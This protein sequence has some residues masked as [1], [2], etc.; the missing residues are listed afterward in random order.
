MRY[1]YIVNGNT[2]PG[3]LETTRWAHSQ[4]TYRQQGYE[5]PC[6]HGNFYLEPSHQNTPQTVYIADA[7]DA[8]LPMNLPEH[9]DNTAGPSATVENERKQEVSQS[10]SSTEIP[11]SV[12]SPRTLDLGL[13]YN[14]ILEFE[15]DLKLL[16]EC[17]EEFWGGEEHV[18]VIHLL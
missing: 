12:R 1:N 7:V 3:L 13:I 16:R 15:K 4:P 6:D 17:F 9:D 2:R 5:R 10:A 11:N 8:T 14:A 18:G